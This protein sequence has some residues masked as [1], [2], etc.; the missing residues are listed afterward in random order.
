M[1]PFT[2]LTDSMVGMGGKKSVRPIHSPTRI[3]RLKF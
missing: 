1:K 2:D 3:Q